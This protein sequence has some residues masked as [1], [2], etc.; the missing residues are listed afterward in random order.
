MQ[1]FQYHKMMYRTYY[2]LMVILF[3]IAIPTKTYAVDEISTSEIKASWIYTLVDWLDWKN[4]SKSGKLTICAVGRDK[5]Y[6]YLK[7]ME[8]NSYNKKNNRKFSVQNKSPKDDF[9]ECNILYISESEQEYYMNM[10]NTISGAQGVITISSISGFASHGG[11]IEFVIKK[12]ARLIMNLKVMRNAK[13]AIDDELYG[14][15]ETIN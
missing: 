13:V 5:V 1:K 15:V 4:H 6:L 2:V 11:A 3:L 14:W 10:L 12:K 7:R 9:K 8:T